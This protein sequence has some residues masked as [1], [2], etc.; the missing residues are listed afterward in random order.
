M[1]LIVLDSLAL[2]FD[3]GQQVVVMQ[4]I[5]TEP[6]GDRSWVDVEVVEQERPTEGEDLNDRQRF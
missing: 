6:R 4:D 5:Y 2:S 3:A 1:L